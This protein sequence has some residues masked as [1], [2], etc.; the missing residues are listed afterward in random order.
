MG[1]G[2]L[3]EKKIGIIANPLWISNYVCRPLLCTKCHHTYW[4]GYYCTHTQWASTSCI[5]IMKIQQRIGLAMVLFMICMIYQLFSF[6]LIWL[7][8]LQFYNCYFV[9]FVSMELRLQRLLISSFYS[10]QLMP[11]VAALIG[12]LLGIQHTWEYEQNVFR[13]RHVVEKGQWWY[14]LLRRVH[15]THYSGST[16]AGWLYMELATHPTMKSA[17][18]LTNFSGSSS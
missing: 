12:I 15:E 6:L 9:F 1:T 13:A 8:L 11:N 3:F 7:L 18:V 2:F 10:D 4:W 14:K 17:M 16:D 5:H